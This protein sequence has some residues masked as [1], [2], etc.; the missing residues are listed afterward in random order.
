MVTRIYGMWHLKQIW[1]PF[2]IHKHLL[3]QSADHKWINTLA[4]FT[5]TNIKTD[6]PRAIAAIP[7]NIVLNTG[8]FRNLFTY[9]LSCLAGDEF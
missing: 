4:I 3:K 9:L 1:F 2:Y 5:Q 8:M 6:I 7:T